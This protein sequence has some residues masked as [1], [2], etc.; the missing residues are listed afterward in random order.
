VPDAYIIP[1]AILATLFTFGFVWLS[2]DLAY[3]ISETRYQRKMRAE[4]DAL[5]DD[6]DEP[7]EAERPK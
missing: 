3:K 2:W 5:L 6:T 7:R 1:I 4:A